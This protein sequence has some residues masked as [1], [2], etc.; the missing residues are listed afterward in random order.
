MFLERREDA[1]ELREN[2]EESGLLS[3]SRVF[4]ARSRKTDQ[5]NYLAPATQA[6]EG[7]TKMFILN[8]YMAITLSIS[9]PMYGGTPPSAPSVIR[10][11]LYYDHFFSAPPN[12]RTILFLI[13][14]KTVNTANGHIL[15][16]ETVESFIILARLYGHSVEI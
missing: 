10:S 6:I 2:G 9:G 8:T 16:S 13:L 7:A 4:L 15:K 3:P 11:P 5:K 12:G 14:K 1:L